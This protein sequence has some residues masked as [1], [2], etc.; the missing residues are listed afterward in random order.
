M[1]ELKANKIKEYYIKGEFYDWVTK[2]KGFERIFHKL[3]EKVTLGLIKNYCHASKVLDVGCGTGLLTRH[4]K[5]EIVLGLDI[6]NWN[7]KR[8]REHAPKTEVILGD[9][10]SLPIRLE[11]IDIIVCT[12]VLEHLLHPEEVL[13]E[14]V[15]VLRPRGKIIGSVPSKNPIWGFRK[16]L[17]STCLV[18]E[19]FHRNYSL[20]E[21]LTLLQTSGKLKIIDIGLSKLVLGLTLFFIVEKSC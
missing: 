13:S 20:K 12:E 19:P 8:T 1:E 16:Y 5:G 17:T 18:A 21:L 7:L 3:R 10:E 9:A 6:N 14:M 2:P 15:R 4:I 11:S